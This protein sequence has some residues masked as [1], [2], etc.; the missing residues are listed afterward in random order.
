MQK[1]FI[2]QHKK[3]HIIVS[4]AGNTMRLHVPMRLVNRA[5]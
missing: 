3:I 5:A 4:F 1:R 2:M